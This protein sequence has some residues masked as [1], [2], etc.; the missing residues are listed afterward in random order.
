MIEDKKEPTAVEIKGLAE[1]LGME[2]PTSF[3]TATDTDIELIC[4]G[5][6]PERWPD[7]ARALIEKVLSKLFGT[8]IAFAFYVCAC[9][10][11]WIYYIGKT[12]LAKK[13]GDDSFGTNMRIAIMYYT[14]W[15]MLMK[16]E[17]RKMVF[18]AF[19]VSI[20]MEIVVELFGDEAFWVGKEKPV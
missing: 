18:T 12:K 1:K 3:R 14:S 10:H 11:D 5:I 4:N 6:G 16:K 17:G 13:I 19:A 9:I 15:R 20:V 2:I 7:V 8:E